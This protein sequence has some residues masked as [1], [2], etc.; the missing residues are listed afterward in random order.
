[1]ETAVEVEL[2][3]KPDLDAMGEGLIKEFTYLPSQAEVALTFAHG[4]RKLLSEERHW[5]RNTLA[6]TASTYYNKNGGTTDPLSPEAVSWCLLGAGRR[7][8]Y[9]LAHISGYDY[10]MAKRGSRSFC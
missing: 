3:T 9:E 8:R 2:V 1:M 10:E 4:I 7:V 6:R 5:T